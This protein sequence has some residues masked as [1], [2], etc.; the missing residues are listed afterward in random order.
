MKSRVHRLLIPIVAAALVVG[1]ARREG[2]AAAPPAAPAQ[3]LFEEGRRL[4]KAEK[5]DQACD[6]FRESQ[7]LDPGA[8]TLLNL[9]I[10][11]EKSGKTASAWATYQEAVFASEQSNRKD[12]A[13]RAR[14][15]VEALR[16]LL[17][18]L[19]IEVPPSSMVNGLVVERDDVVV[20]PA[21]WGTA[22]PVDPGVH[23]VKAH[24]PGHR[25]Q[26]W[27]V[28][29]EGDRQSIRLA[30]ERLAASPTSTGDEAV[31]RGAD[32]AR[33][34]SENVR[35]PIGFAVA[36]VGVV[37]IGVGAFFG[38]R[39]LSSKSAAASDGHCTSDLSVCDPS[40][41][42]SMQDAHKD[43]LFSTIGF[44]A[45]GV[46]LGTGVVLLL[47]SKSTAPASAHGERIHLEMTG[48]GVRVGGAF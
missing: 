41:I 16:P 15:E 21:E 11:Y 8:G 36:G 17:S 45:G 44:A 19:T 38:L 42:Q 4:M 26:S 28:T 47:T 40:G 22:I 6:K 34:D 27:T 30:V 39:A 1:A 14:S 25:A 48:S 13:K 33:S 43:A 9:A 3:A 20:A 10:C 23:V 35:R 5:F 32:R 37:G 46:L 2:L 29:V 12:W 7:R 24:A 31:G 18:S